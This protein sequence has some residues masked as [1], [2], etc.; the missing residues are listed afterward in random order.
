[1]PNRNQ[2]VVPQARG[3]LENLKFE[4]A[5]ELGISNYQGYKGDLPSKIN[6]AVGGNMVRKM[7]RLA[8]TQIAGGTGTV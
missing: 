7:I 1:M 3:A 6:G 2:A 5:Q 4:T 8:E